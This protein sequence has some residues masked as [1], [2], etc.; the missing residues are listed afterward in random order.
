MS[1]LYLTPCWRLDLQPTPKF[2]LISLADQANDDGECWP[3][4][5]SLVKRTGF[6]DRTVQTAVRFLE[7]VGIVTREDRPGR[8]TLYRLTP[9][10][11]SPP[12]ELH[13]RSTI[14]PPPKELHPTPEGASDHI[15]ITDPKEN[16]VAS[17]QSSPAPKRNRREIPVLPED[18]I[19]IRI[20]CLGGEYPIA[21]TD[22]EAWAE[23]FPAVDVVADLRLARVWCE[24]N[25]DRRKTPG[26][27]RRFITKWLMKTQNRG[28]NRGRPGGGGPAPH[29]ERPWI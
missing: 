23:A 19:A 13:P 10:A 9:E 20:P 25:P 17:D 7:S 14:T 22:V 6:S 15:T 26:G 16:R 24:A 8:S 3:A 18:E 4:I 21:K 12:K 1:N 11:Y 28:G 5:G 2:V 27:V 29:N